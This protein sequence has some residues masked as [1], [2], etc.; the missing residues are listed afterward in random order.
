MGKPFK[1]VVTCSISQKAG[2]GLH[3][4]A[5]ARWN[6]KTDGRLGVHW[7]SETVLA[8]VTVFWVAI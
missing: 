7:E 6:P 8:L 5:C 2:A 4:A 3:A 1:Y